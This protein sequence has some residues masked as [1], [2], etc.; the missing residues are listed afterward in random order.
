MAVLLVTAILLTQTLTI[1]FTITRLLS[2]DIVPIFGIVLS[3][4][5]KE[6]LSIVLAVTPLILLLPGLAPKIRLML[7]FTT[8]LWMRLFIP[9]GILSILLRMIVTISTTILQKPLSIPISVFLLL[10]PN[11]IAVLLPTL[12]LF[13]TKSVS[14]SLVICPLP[15]PFFIKI[16]RH[17]A[18]PLSTDKILSTGC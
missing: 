18:M 5:G 4:I 14:V 1:R 10:F 16:K 12:S 17:A 2:D 3:A 15:G 9:F 13:L 6:P 8:S 7:D 11:L